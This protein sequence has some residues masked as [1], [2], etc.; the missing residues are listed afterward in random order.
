MS[1][2]DCN[3]VRGAAAAHRD[4]KLPAAE[5]ARID[6]HLRGCPAC[7]EVFAQDG[8]IAA[9]A[10]ETR[11][12]PA[13]DTRTVARNVRRGLV[14]GALREGRRPAW[15][16]QLRRLGRIARPHL[17]RIARSRVPAVAMVL[18]ALALAYEAGRRAA[19]TPTPSPPLSADGGA[20]ADLLEGGAGPACAGDD[21]DHAL[22]QADLFEDLGEAEC[23]EG[24]GFGGLE[25][26]RVAAG[27]RGSE[28]PRGHK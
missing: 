28:L 1:R 8:R 6:A 25:H 12:S 19:E 7:R 18:F 9:L 16:R 23:G 22:G 2:L 11:R 17:T 10:R 27:E 21:V 26:A 20:D 24:C 14:E 3:R 5:A 15:Q 4:R 13:G